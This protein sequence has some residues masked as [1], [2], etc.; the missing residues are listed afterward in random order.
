M[1]KKNAVNSKSKKKDKSF[2]DLL[3]RLEKIVDEMENADPGLD[4]ALELF[5]EGVELVR[6]CSSKI[7]EA[8]R[9][10]EILVKDNGRIRKEN[11]E[12]EEEE[13]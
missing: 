12:N 2:E 1:L 9:R 10:V 6:F 11:F 7:N 3:K 5:T 13:N 4:K 8:K